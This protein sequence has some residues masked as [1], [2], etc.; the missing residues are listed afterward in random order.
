MWQ[1]DVTDSGYYITLR[2]SV[3]HIVKIN[4]KNMIYMKKTLYIKKP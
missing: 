2:T 3:K 1:I 4:V